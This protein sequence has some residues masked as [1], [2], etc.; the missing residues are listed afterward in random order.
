MKKKLNKRGNGNYEFLLIAIVC[1]ILTAAILVIAIRS[2]DDEK[3]KVFRYNAKTIAL[4]AVII[5]NETNR[6][7][8]YLQEMLDQGLISPIKNPFGEEK[9]CNAAES[10]VELIHGERHVTLQCGDHLIYKQ[11]LTDKTYTVYQV[12]K[13][14]EEKKE[15][16]N[17]ERVV[18]NLK[19]DGQNIFEVLQ[20]EV[21]FLNNVNKKFGT[22][23]QSVDQ[24]DKKYELITIKQYRKRSK[25]KEV[26]S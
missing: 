13:W 18:Y 10:K 1:L 5:E 7:I 26:K 23:Y 22:N 15:T 17:E 11:K 9:T 2:S 14:S 16:S 24:I 8:V 21:L 12:T 25:V 6:E 4:N 3:F 19:S 20:E